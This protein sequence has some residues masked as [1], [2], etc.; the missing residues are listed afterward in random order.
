MA[1]LDHER[2]C[3]ALTEETALLREALHG[4]DPGIK[5]PTCPEWTLRELAGHVGFAHRW[6]EEIVRTRATAQVPDSAVWDG[7]PP[8]DPEGLDNWLA[9][10]AGRLAATLREAGPDLPVWSWT[11]DRRTGVWARRMALETLV[12]RA[13]AAI[14]AEFPFEAEPEPAADAIDERL[15]L[16]TSPQAARVR[17]ERRE[18]LGTGET[19]HLHATDAPPELHAEWLIERGPR[20]VT[21]RRAHAKADVAVRAPLTELMLVVHRRLALDDDRLEIF[22]DRALLEH[23]LARTAF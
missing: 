2:Y 5:V 11:P 23:W 6:V 14:A 4:A 21:W 9:D 20:A 16:V 8:G 1:G 22:G 15:E 10:G 3:V 17:P 13:D 18:L 7:V 12:H 19:L